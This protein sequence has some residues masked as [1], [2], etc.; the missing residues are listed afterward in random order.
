M[1]IDDKIKDRIEHALFIMLAHLN[2]IS[3]SNLA[4]LN[5]PHFNLKKEK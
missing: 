3:I 2:G 5:I 1:Q 4:W